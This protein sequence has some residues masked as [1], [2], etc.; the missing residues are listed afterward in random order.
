[1]R[2]RDPNLDLLRA[3]A[4]LLVLV[5]HITPRWPNVPVALTTYSAFGAT[6]VDLFFVLSGWLIGGLLWREQVQFGDVEVRRFVARRALRTMPPYLV[7]MAISFLGVYVARREP[8]Q[9]GYLFF[10][11]N[12]SWHMP[13][14]LIS[15]SL[16]V[17]E[18]FYLVM[19]LAAVALSRLP[20][21]PFL[22]PLLA[23]VPLACRAFTPVPNPAIFGFPA[24]ATHLHCEGLILGVWA[25]YLRYKQPGIWD[26]FRRFAARALIPAFL[27]VIAV[28]CLPDRP[29]YDFFGTAI[30]VFFLFLLVSVVERRA[31]FFS[32]SR[33][34]FWV[35]S[36][37]Y[38]VY[39][40]H[41]FTLDAGLRLINRMPAITALQL[42]VLLSC[43]ALMGLVFYRCV[44]VPS[45][46]A[47]HRWMPARS[48]GRS[49]LLDAGSTPGVA[50]VEERVSP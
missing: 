20:A 13:F 34:V 6:G 14:F 37:S 15:W 46:A 5:A 36:T 12:Y 29:F 28:A 39:L 10:L 4:I 18:H 50:Y 44:E 48:G 11:Q 45:L 21:R 40:T 22:V 41:A 43:I 26:G 25:A 38:S 42:P 49:P 19:P 23:L 27:V 1:M 32:D 30:A 7:A 8:F 33:A 47:R 35:A 31:Y 3:S 24:T 2:T 16:C 17:E 9:W